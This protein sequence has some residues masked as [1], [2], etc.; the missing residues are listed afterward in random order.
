MHNGKRV[1]S[2]LQEQDQSMRE[3]LR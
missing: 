1:S 3:L 2:N